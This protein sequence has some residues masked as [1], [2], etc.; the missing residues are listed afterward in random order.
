M[1]PS[2][3]PSIAKQE[4]CALIIPKSNPQQKQAN[5]T[6]ATIHRFLDLCGGYVECETEELMNVMITPTCLMGP[7]YGILRQNQEWLVNKGVP[8]EDATYFIGKQYAS[9]MADAERGCHNN[10]QHFEDLVEEQ[11]PGGLNE[12]VSIDIALVE[13]GGNIDCTLFL[14]ESS[15]R[16]I[17]H[18]L[19]LCN[20]CML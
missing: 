3:L 6:I 2:G 9:M 15:K 20:A 16:L 4:G 13:G 8:Q 11:T 17:A 14:L 5:P 19:V 7:F 10:P 1:H 12:Q 18:F